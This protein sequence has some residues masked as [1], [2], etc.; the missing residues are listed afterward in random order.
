MKCFSDIMNID[1]AT[2]EYLKNEAKEAWAIARDLELRM[3]SWLL[4]VF[5]ILTTSYPSVVFGGQIHC[6]MFAMPLVEFQSHFKIFISSKI[7][8]FEHASGQIRVL[9]NSVCVYHVQIRS[10][11]WHC[12]NKSDISCPK[13]QPG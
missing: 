3:L 7:R 4:K 11:V 8:N 5:D 6:S 13:N 9:T 2:I 10:T 12:R 1:D